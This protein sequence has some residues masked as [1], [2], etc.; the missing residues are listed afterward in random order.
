[1]DEILQLKIKFPSGERWKR[2][3]IENDCTFHDLYKF[4]FEILGHDDSTHLHEFIITDDITVAPES[5]VGTTGE[6]VMDF[7]GKKDVNYQEKKTKLVEFLNREKQSII[8]R[9]D[10][11]VNW[12]YEIVV[13]EIIE[14]EN[15]EEYEDLPVTIEDNF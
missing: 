10:F 2:I 6:E 7:W 12:R 14:K 4:L 1:M 8:Y 9:F 5:N 3:L 11:G 15:I 13:E